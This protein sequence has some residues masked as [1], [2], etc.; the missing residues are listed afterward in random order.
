MALITEKIKALMK[1]S[2]NS[3]ELTVDIL[4][5]VA[6]YG[7]IFILP[8][9]MNILFWMIFAVSAFLFCIGFF[10]TGFIIDKYNTKK[11][12]RVSGFLL[13]IFG[14]AL[15]FTGGFAIWKKHGSEN[16]ICIAILLL[17]EAIVIYSIIASLADA[18]R[19]QWTMSM[20][21]RV[22]AVLLVIGAIA[23]I[24]YTIITSVSNTTIAIGV[25]L[26]IEGIV[27]WAM[28]SGNNPFNSS[29]SSI[30]VVPGM[31]KT[32]RELCD[33]LAAT[34]TQLGFPWIGKIRTIKEETIIYGP[35]EYDGFVYGYFHFGKFYIAY[36]DD[37]SLLD[38]AQANT[39]RITEIPDSKGI[40]LA[41]NS[42]PEAY[43][44]MIT[45]YLE[46]GNIIWSTKL[47]KH[48]K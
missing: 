32:V 38:A 11:A 10:R 17:I 43:S 2:G 35:T 19:V 15:N 16:G 33:A 8:Q 41:E 30:S 37:I 26:L 13:L 45:R 23:A 46:N 44:N 22:A 9:K 27:F 21:F 3:T 34:E 14:I 1:R 39:H 6:S 31:N 42:L 25:Y 12:K 40:C 18:P 7:L 29:F 20:I 5:L 4:C 36:S 47:N 48:K 28:G 24:V